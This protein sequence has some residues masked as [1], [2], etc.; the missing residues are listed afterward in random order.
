MN[1]Y[2]KESKSTQQLR[3]PKMISVEKSP[4]TTA[5]ATRSKQDATKQKMGKDI[6]YSKSI[7]ESDSFISYCSRF[8]SWPIQDNY[9]SA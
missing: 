4:Y 5:E 9:E 2:T 3:L 7:A 6:Q 1:A 8:L